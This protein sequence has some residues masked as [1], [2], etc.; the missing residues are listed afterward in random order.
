[1]RGIV[2]I[3][4][5]KK[6]ILVNGN[7]MHSDKLNFVLMKE[8][9]IEILRDA[10]NIP[11]L[12]YNADLAISSGGNMMYEFACVGIPIIC[13][14][15][16]K[17]EFNLCNEFEMRNIAIN[18]GYGVDV[19]AIDLVGYVNLL[20]NSPD[21]R[22]KMIDNGKKYVDGKGLERVLKIINQEE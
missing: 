3:G 13:L 15:E 9:N 1:M 16:D 20:M 10:P 7:F 5:I 2:G 4:I 18:L 22:Q 17:A 6:T 8:H 12:I 14:P 21:R 11:E 19:S